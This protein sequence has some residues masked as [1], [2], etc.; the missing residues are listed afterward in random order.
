M[1][2]KEIPMDTRH[3]H[4]SDYDYPLLDE[5]I[6]KFPK[7]ERDTSKLLVYRKVKYVRTS[8]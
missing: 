3:I 8:S 5:R 1:F 4:I 2:I 6:A 7:T